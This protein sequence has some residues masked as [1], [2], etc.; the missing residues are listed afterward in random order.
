MKVKYIRVSTEEQNIQRQQPGDNSFCKIYV[1]R[2]SGAN[3]FQERPG[4]G[5][6]LSDIYAGV[7][8]EVHVSSVDRLGRNILDILTVIDI[9]NT[10]KV[11]LYIENIGLYSL[12]NDK[13]NS[14]FSMIVSVLANIAEIEL[15]N[16]RERQREGIEIAKRKGVY[17]GRVKGSKMSDEELLQKY[18]TVVKELRRGESLRRAAKLGG[19]SL[20]TVQKIKRLVF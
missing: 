3:K 19:C 17:T 18:K 8:S 15:N 5:K 16:M 10:H 7:I 9:F 1:D 14:V 12:V 4:A 20:G 11:Q 6:L 2:I 13:P